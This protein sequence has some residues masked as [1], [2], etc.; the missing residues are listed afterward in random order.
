[1]IPG[2]GR[3]LAG[4]LTSTLYRYAWA[5]DLAALDSS[6]FSPGNAGTDFPWCD[7]SRQTVTQVSSG[8]LVEKIEAKAEQYASL[9]GWPRPFYA[10][11]SADEDQI[12]IDICSG[13]DSSNPIPDGALSQVHKF[14]TLVLTINSRHTVAGRPAALPRALLFDVGDD[15]SSPSNGRYGL[16]RNFPPQWINGVEVGTG[17][18][19]EVKGNRNTK[20]GLYDPATATEAQLASER[21][22]PLS[23]TWDLSMGEPYSG[24]PLA[25]MDPDGV[26]FYFDALPRDEAT[27]WA[28]P[29]G[30]NEGTDYS[31]IFHGFIMGQDVP[32]EIELPV[33]I[34]RPVL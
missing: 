19:N 29:N 11:G 8:V 25:P 16:W 32:G 4:G 13:T 27:G 17:V 10:G 26:S 12:P 9:L 20:T 3:G 14:L 21:D 34:T 22:T 5:I 7:T 23:I 33:N 15:D 28:I 2:L 31:V 6:D 18:V 30:T 1:M 24:G